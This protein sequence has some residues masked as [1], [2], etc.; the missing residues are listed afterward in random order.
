MLDIVTASEWFG[1][2]F[3]RPIII[4]GPCSAETRE[5]VMSTA[6]AIAEI[7]EVSI[8]RAGV[9]KPRTR[10]GNFEGA[11]NEALEWLAEA[12]AATG[13]KMAVEVATPAHV[14]AALKAGV[15]V[16]WVGARTVSNPFSVQ[17]LAA[18]L[19]GVDVPVL[20]KNPI[21][22]D[23]ELWIGALERI[24]R[25]GCK[26]LAAIHRGFYPFEKRG[27]RNIPRWEVPIELKR[28]FP[29]LPMICDPSHI[30]GKWELV[31]SIAQQALDLDMDGLMIETHINP[32]V[33]LSDA[34]Q[35]L[36]PAQLSEM[37]GSMSFPTS[38]TTDTS[39][40][41]CIQTL[42][43]R[44]DSLDAQMLELI[45]QRMKIAEEIGRF[46][47]QQ[48]VTILQVRRFEQILKDRLEQ[49]EVIGLNHEFVK[50]L[51]EMVHKE[52]ILR[53]EAIMRSSG[54]G[55]RKFPC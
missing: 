14:E 13:L 55:E 43:Q 8:F 32:S 20:V 47:L 6:L 46:K 48:N 44:I 34:R 25:A 17:E 35:Q 3:G 54:P 9:W 40:A 41:R 29:N 23:I 22:P 16:L 39:F 15:D 28:L 7:K 42:R 1:S 50:N 2:E 10:P 12:K 38:T 37:V 19:G 52:S 45:A 51:L 26:K 4:G 24:N 18:A 30:A 5:Q 33:A 53:Q 27:L 31:Q 49:A 21:N 11:G 36:T